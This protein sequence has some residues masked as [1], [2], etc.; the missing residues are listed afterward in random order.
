MNRGTAGMRHRRASASAARA[1]AHATVV[2]DELVGGVCVEH[3]PPRLVGVGARALPTGVVVEGRVLDVVVVARAVA[4]LALELRVATEAVDVVATSSDAV[5]EVVDA[6]R[7]ESRA[8]AIAQTWRPAVGAGADA[9]QWTNL[10]AGGRVLLV[11]A[12]SSTVRRIEAVANRAGVRLG[13]VEP[14]AA[15]RG[16]LGAW[17]AGRSRSGGRVIRVAEAL[18]G[19]LLRDEHDGLAVPAWVEAGVGAALAGLEASSD[20]GR[21]TRRGPGAPIDLRRPAATIPVTARP[22]GAEKTAS[23]DRAWVVV[24]AGLA[25]VPAG[26]GQ[27]GASQSVV[28]P[29]PLRVGRFPES[30]LCG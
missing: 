10:P 2:T 17:P 13:R 3:W 7:V 28:G 5:A 16:R 12:L 11:G 29:R 9:W 15:A 8:A 27:R 14:L 25:A 26:W 18:G 6:S 1:C 19:V 23:S 22:T 21:G 24:P 4:G 30:Q 20:G